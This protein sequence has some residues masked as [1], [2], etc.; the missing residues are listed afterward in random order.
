MDRKNIMRR[1]L[2]GAAALA[3]LYVLL[4]PWL[5]PGVWGHRLNGED[6][7]RYRA[8]WLDGDAMTRANSHGR[9]W[10]PI[11]PGV[12]TSVLPKN[13]S[14]RDC[15]R[16][17]TLEDIGPRTVGNAFEFNFWNNWTQTHPRPPDAIERERIGLARSI[18]WSRQDFQSGRNLARHTAK[19]QAEHEARLRNELIA[20]GYPPEAFT[21]EALFTNSMNWKEEYLSRLKSEGVDS[22]YVEAYRRAWTMKTNEQDASNQASQDTS[23]RADPE[24]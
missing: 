7:W 14:K 22:S 10:P 12:D 11:P 6:F 20:T 23:L 18:Q 13:V 21:D 16:E 15:C 3:L 1:V 2:L 5:L 19:S 9:S 24:R 17:Y 8:I 4:H